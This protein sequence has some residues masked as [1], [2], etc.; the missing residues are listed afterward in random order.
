MLAEFFNEEDFSTLV[1]YRAPE[2]AAGEA[3]PRLIVGSSTVSSG[4]GVVERTVAFNELGTQAARSYLDANCAACHQ[5]SAPRPAG[6]DLRATT[7]IEDTGL[8]GSDPTYGDLGRAGSKLIAPGKPKN[9]LL[10]E[11]LRVR[12]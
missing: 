12:L 3:E 11:R 1:V 7:A 10:L 8:V 9:S 5:P 4:I 2:P 6:L